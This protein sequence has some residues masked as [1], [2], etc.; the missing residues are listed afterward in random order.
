[1]SVKSAMGDLI[2]GLTGLQVKRVQSLT[3]SQIHEPDDY[4][5]WLFA[6]AYVSPMH[7][8]QVKNWGKDEIDG[9]DDFQASTTTKAVAEMLKGEDGDE[10][11]DPKDAPAN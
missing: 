5:A 2:D 8:E 9:F 1:M 6:L 4:Y 3:G 11:T 7:P 10:D